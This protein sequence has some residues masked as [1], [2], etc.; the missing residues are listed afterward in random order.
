M[1]RRSDIIEDHAAEWLIRMEFA[2]SPRSWAALDSW[3]AT[4][5]RHRAAFLRLSVAWHRAEQLRKLK[6][7][8]GVV[9][10]DLLSLP[11]LRARRAAARARRWRRPALAVGLPTAAAAALLAGIYLLLPYALQYLR[12]EVYTTDVGNRRHIELADGSTVE[13]NT[14]SLLRVRFTDNSRELTLLRGEA[15]FKAAHNSARPFE[16]QA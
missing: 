12:T 8:D 5:P 9:D 2:G 10:E 3:I 14:D 11:A 15:A 7:F 6:A 16:V 13:L 1:A 4:H